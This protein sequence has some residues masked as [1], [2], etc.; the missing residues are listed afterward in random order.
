[1]LALCG[2]ARAG[3]RGKPPCWHKVRRGDTLAK[4]ARRYYGRTDAWT[5]IKKANPGL[6]ERNLKVGRRIFIPAASGPAKRPEPDPQPRPAPQPKPHAPGDEEPIPGTAE[7]VGQVISSLISLPFSFLFECLMLWLASWLMRRQFHIRKPTFMSALR[8]VFFTYL[9]SIG[10]MLC[11]LI[12]VSPVFFFA[13]DYPIASVIYGSVV[14]LA[15]ILM[16]IWANCT[17]LAKNYRITKREGFALLVV[18][19]LCGFLLG[20]CLSMIGYLVMFMI[21]GGSMAALS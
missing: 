5:R 11:G 4:I 1:M 16:M 21:L 10:V 13:M 2:A 6:D 8:G 15:T 18:W 19:S 14:G 12:V 7:I 20:C 17:V 3:E 9:A